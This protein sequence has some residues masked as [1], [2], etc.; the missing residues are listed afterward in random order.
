[1]KPVSSYYPVFMDLRGRRCIVIGGGDVALRKVNALLECG[2]RVQVISPEICDGLN[3][4]AR[5]GK[6]TVTTR[7][8]ALGDL[9]GA[10]LAIAAT[11]DEETNR[12]VA[13]EAEKN[14]IPVNVVDEPA[15]CSFIVPSVVRRGD[16]T[17]AVSTGGQSPALAHKVRTN[18]EKEFGEEY[19]ELTRLTGEVR[20]ELKS[21]GVK[22]KPED[23]Q[24]ALDIEAMLALLKQ[25]RRD[26]ARTIMVRSL[27][28][29]EADKQNVP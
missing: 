16:L 20:R 28:G 8:Y 7:E 13:A 11:G 19:A 23:W 24:S 12:R 1:M 18:L 25:G 17:L 29:A 27:L 10:L 9:A 15:L 2:A 26:E 22:A 14:H 5:Q 4:L 3:S 6:V 21:R